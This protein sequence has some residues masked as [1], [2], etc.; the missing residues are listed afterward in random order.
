MER[1]FGVLIEHYAGNFPLWLAPV[2][3][4]VLPVSDPFSDYA[5]EVARRLKAAGIRAEVD[6]QDAK[7]GYKIREAEVQKIPYMLIVGKQEV[8]GGTVSVRR[9]GEGDLGKLSLEDVTA[10]MQQEIQE[11]KMS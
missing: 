11:K 2:Q 3:A 6:D 7:L 4:I 9:H 1:F 10:K 5:A 8:G